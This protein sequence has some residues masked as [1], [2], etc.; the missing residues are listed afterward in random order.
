MNRHLILS[1]NSHGTFTIILPFQQDYCLPLNCDYLSDV[2]GLCR[3]KPRF[4]GSP[5]KI[6]GKKNITE[7]DVKKV[8]FEGSSC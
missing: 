1:S 6:R 2:F 3:K 4:S 7:T 8:G 5:K